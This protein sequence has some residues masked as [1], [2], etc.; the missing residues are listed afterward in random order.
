MSLFSI[1]YVCFLIIYASYLQ[2]FSFSFLSDRTA[3]DN[4]GG[5]TLRQQDAITRS[6][7][8]WRKYIWHGTFSLEPNDDVTSKTSRNVAL[9]E[10]IS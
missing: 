6:R 2:I 10:K 5:I 9:F 7:D 3:T 1:N 8:R 4:C